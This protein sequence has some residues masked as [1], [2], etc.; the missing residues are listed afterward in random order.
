[1]GLF[2]SM[3]LTMV[4]VLIIFAVLQQQIV[5]GLTVGAIKG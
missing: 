3:T 1:V 2:A 5:K 4:P